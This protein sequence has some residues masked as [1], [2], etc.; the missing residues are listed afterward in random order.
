MSSVSIV[1]LRE[2]S[3]SLKDDLSYIRDFLTKAREDFDDV[4]SQY[5]DIMSYQDKELEGERVV[6]KRDETSSGGEVIHKEITTKTYVHFSP[7]TD[8]NSYFNRLNSYCVAAER[9]LKKL[10]QQVQKIDDSAN[11]IEGNEKEIVA[12]LM[13]IEKSKVLNEE[14]PI[15]SIGALKEDDNRKLKEY[16]DSKE[17]PITSIGA[18]KEDDNRKLK[19][20]ED[21]KEPPITSI[22]ALKED[23]NRKLKEYKEKTEKKEKE[24]KEDVSGDTGSDGNDY[25][26]SSGHDSS[27]GGHSSSSRSGGSS[28]K[29]SK[30]HESSKKESVGLKFISNTQ[31]DIDNENTVEGVALSDIKKSYSEINDEENLRIVS[32]VPDNEKFVTGTDEFQNLANKALESV[33][34]DLL[35]NKNIDTTASSS[36]SDSQI[37]S[38]NISVPSNSE[39]VPVITQTSNVSESPSNNAVDM[40]DDIYSAPVYESIPNTGIGDKEISTNYSIPVIAGVIGGAGIGLGLREKMKD[41]DEKKKSTIEENNN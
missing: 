25:G 39:S 7:G 38:S 36:S 17:P 5:N 6:K 26:S 15:T 8:F 10:E 11:D 33:K 16:E 28:G 37:N 24:T 3:G 30:S 29:S 22:G 21:S 2:V 35:Q 18:L 20:Y 41:D 4:K 32:D 40:T 27:S 13:A 34:N 1:E 12:A 31:K 9:D 23:D 14:K 19:E